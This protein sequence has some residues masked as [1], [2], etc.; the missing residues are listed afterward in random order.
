MKKRTIVQKVIAF[1]N[2]GDEVKLA[3]FETKFS[4]YIKKQVSYREDNIE[5]LRDKIADAKEA[6][7]E[8]V[9][10]INLSSI[11]TTE[12]AETYCANYF[13]QVKR[14]NKVVTELEAKISVLEEEIET[15]K[16]VESLVFEQGE[17][18]QDEKA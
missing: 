5:T 10:N 17:E 13:E 3:R 14:A 16:N 11:S 4:K 12:G 7:K 2:G 8:A 15:I 18:G 6:A 9:L 1:L